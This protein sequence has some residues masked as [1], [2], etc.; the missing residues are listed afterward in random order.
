MKT[1]PLKSTQPQNHFHS[2]NFKE[3]TDLMASSSK[4]EWQKLLKSQVSTIKLENNEPK[5]RKAEEMLDKTDH[6]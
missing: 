3:A 2:V 4:D 6:T 5:K 1:K